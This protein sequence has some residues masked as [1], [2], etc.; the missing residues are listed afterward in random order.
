[1]T[2]KLSGC[3]SRVHLETDERAGGEKDEKYG[4]ISGLKREETSP[5]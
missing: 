1:M 2:R 5:L 3:I 4:L